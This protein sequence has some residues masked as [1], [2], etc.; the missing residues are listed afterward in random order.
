M[1]PSARSRSVGGVY[2]EPV[3]RCYAACCARYW[4]HAPQAAA[5]VTAASLDHLQG[6]AN[7]A[8]TKRVTQWPPFFIWLDGASRPIRG[9]P[10][11]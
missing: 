11:L 4:R 9:D 6:Q 2:F 8:K 7:M 1:V 10:E 3:C 5:T